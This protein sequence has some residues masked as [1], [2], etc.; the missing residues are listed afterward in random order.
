MLRALTHTPFLYFHS[1]HERILD[2]THVQVLILD[3]PT[4]YLDIESLFALQQATEKF[5]GGIIVVSHDRDF[6]AA[7][8]KTLWVLDK[9]SMKVYQEKEFEAALERYVAGEIV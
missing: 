2:P 6:S 4:N 7:F 3:E 5:P 1:R 9:G 8:C